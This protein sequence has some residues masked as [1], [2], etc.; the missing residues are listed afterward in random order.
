MFKKINKTLA[1]I[2]VVA[3]VAISFMTATVSASYPLSN[4][5]WKFY[6]DELKY[7]SGGIDGYVT[8][9]VNGTSTGITF[10]CQTFNNGGYSNFYAWGQIQDPRL[11]A[12]KD[13]GAKLDSATKRSTDQFCNDWFELNNYNSTVRFVIYSDTFTWGANQYVTGYAC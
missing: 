6:P 2:V 10:Q 11:R 4:T 9:L 7:P 12:G 5:D 1:V 8:G 13:N 3:V